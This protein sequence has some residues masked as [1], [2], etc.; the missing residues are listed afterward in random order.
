[1]GGR[2]NT[3]TGGG[4]RASCRR[5]EAR[6]RRRQQRFNGFSDGLVLLAAGGIRIRWAGS[7]YAGGT[8]T[9]GPSTSAEPILTGVMGSSKTRCDHEVDDTF[10]VRAAL[11][12]EWASAKWRW[13]RTLAAS[14]GS[15]SRWCRHGMASR[16]RR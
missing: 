13:L 10:L 16:A 12:G 4:P 7:T 15:R 8:G 6:I 11:Q 3:F 14:A 5:R 1:M 2:P 9:S